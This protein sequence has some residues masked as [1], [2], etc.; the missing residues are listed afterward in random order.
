MSSDSD[1]QPAIYEARQRGAQVWYV[2]FQSRTNRG[3]MLTT[4]Q[5]LLISNDDVAAFYARIDESQL[6][7]RT[8]QPSMTPPTK[9]Q[10]SRPNDRPTSALPSQPLHTTSQ[11]PTTSPSQ[12]TFNR[13]PWSR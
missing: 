13:P 6:T 2:G 9:H 3:L 12:D 7:N 11:P 4:D 10:A 8:S 5:Q 1:L